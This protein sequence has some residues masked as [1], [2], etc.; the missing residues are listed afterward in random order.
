MAVTW[1]E[2]QKVL[3]PMKDY[4]DLCRRF[5][6]SFAYNLVRETF[7]FTIEELIDYTQQVL[8]ED[9][10][11]RYTV[12]AESLVRILKEVHHVGVENLVEL[13]EKTDKQYKLKA[14][15]G[16]SGIQAVDV[17]SLKKYLVYWFV[18][19]E[20]YLSSLVRDDPVISEG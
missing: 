17:V 20:K 10:R 18:P 15:V 6:E 7:N 3:F 12:Y 5:R 13:V 1:D 14:F 8:G 4:E 9:S 16:W 11:K 19:M 2:V